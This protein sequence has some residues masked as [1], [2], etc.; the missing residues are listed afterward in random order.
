MGLLK[1]TLR[2]GLVT[3]GIVGVGVLV[4]GPHRAAALFNRL[5]GAVD[6]AID[7]NID[8]PTA[9]RTQLRTLESQYPQRISELR[10]DLAQLVEQRRQMDRD[11]AVA[12]RVVTLAD[13]DLGALKTLLAQAEVLRVAAAPG[14]V[15]TV[16]FDNDSMPLDQAS[17]RAAQIAQTRTAYA[18]RA[19][20]A[21]RDLTYLGQQQSRLESLLTQLETERA[22][23]Q[24]QIW[25]MDRQVDSIARNDRL[26]ALMSKRQQTMDECSRYEAGSLEQIH[27]HMTEVRSKQE[28]E[29]D[30]L[31][32]T[33]QRLDYEDIARGQID[34]Q[35]LPAE[36]AGLPASGALR[37][38]EA[39]AV[40]PEGGAAPGQGDGGAVPAPIT[41]ARGEVRLETAAPRLR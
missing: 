1:T 3:I 12:E 19:R 36:L 37:S 23:F 41:T 17:K 6:T 34:E 18:S 22:D 27:A 7:K 8:D 21:V 40:V 29:L 14:Q 30:L 4:A 15:V 31:A 11:R 33:Q 35:E 32:D 20:D 38:S 2:I 16:R 9:L 13:Q 24:S 26:I 10:G 25:Q 5:R 39:D 28:A